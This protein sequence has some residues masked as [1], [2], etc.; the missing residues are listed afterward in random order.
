MEQLNQHILVDV[1]DADGF[2]PEEPQASEEL[3]TRESV[4]TDDPVRTYLREMGSISLLTRQGEVDL[5]RRMERGTQRIR[6]A[7]SRT[8]AVEAAV[9]SIFDGLRRDEIRLAEVVEIGGPTQEA[10]EQSR[11]RA[12]D[13]FAQAAKAGRAVISMRQKLD[14]TPRR[15]V[16][17]RA[18]LSSKLA[19]LQ[20]RFSQTIRAIPFSSRQWK[21]FT[22]T[23][24][25]AAASGAAGMPLRL[26]QLR[27]GE[28]EVEFAK[29]ALVEANLRLV[30][31]VAKKYANHGLHLLDLIQEGNLGLIRASEKFDYR[32]GFKF[33][34]YATWWI[35]QA[36][37][38]AIDDQSRTIRIP[39]HVN[40][41]L[42]KFT[43]ASR[44]LEKQLGRAPTDEE[45]GVRLETTAQ[46]VKELRMLA[47]DPVSLDLPVGRDGESALGDLIED[48][49]VASVLDTLFEGDVRQKT[50]GVLRS[51]SPTEEKV[52]RMRFGIGCEREHTLA[53]IANQMN[54]SRERIRQIENGALQ[55][56]R[57][58]GAAHRL[59]PLVSI[60]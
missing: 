24:E 30:V 10:K 20:V 31:S 15:H 18:R 39:V 50:A 40:E 57:S 1:F 49:S 7:L 36:I 28:T 56:L 60:Q 17:L 25:R 12:L 9:L 8:P 55:Q 19:R 23:L 59:Q 47:R 43:G 51:L 33:S 22:V 46:K 42:S 41:T 2:V 34:T 21:E 14:A 53:E 29:N 11:Q 45:I 6:K 13:K 27:Q 4:F 44:D 54:L 35:R 38:R 48:H 37:S 58:P 3:E 26:K 32:L 52:L 16:N 5:A